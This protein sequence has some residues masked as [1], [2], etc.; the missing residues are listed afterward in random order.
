MGSL[1]VFLPV[2]PSLDAPSH[3]MSAIDIHVVGE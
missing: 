2:S 3:P 1:R